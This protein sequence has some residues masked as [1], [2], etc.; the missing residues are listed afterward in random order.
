ML[1]VWQLVQ[2]LGKHD[3]ILNIKLPHLGTT[4]E[5]SSP[6]EPPVWPARGRRLLCTCVNSRSRLL[7]TWRA[8]CVRKS[9]NAYF[10]PF[11]ILVFRSDSLL[12]PLVPLPANQCNVN[13]NHCM[14]ST[15]VMRF[16]SSSKPCMR[17]QP[18]YFLLGSP[19]GPKE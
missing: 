1:R 4:R 12:S 19:K 11:S 14:Q 9:G 15:E 8:C 6:R 16:S 2:L 17:I 13:E 10:Y 5:E 7:S 3:L 18:P